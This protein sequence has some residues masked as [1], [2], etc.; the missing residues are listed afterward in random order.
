MRHTTSRLRAESFFIL[1]SSSATLS[2]PSPPHFSIIQRYAYCS[3]VTSAVCLL[4][5]PAP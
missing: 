2:Q 3:A 5:A 4:T 1:F